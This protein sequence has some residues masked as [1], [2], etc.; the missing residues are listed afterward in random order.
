MQEVTTLPEDTVINPKSGERI[1]FTTTTQES[2]GE[3]LAFD[4]FVSP[5]GGVDFPHR[6][7]KQREVMR[8]VTGELALKVNGI[9]QVLRPGDELILEAG[10]VH[11]IIN[12]TDSEVHCEVEYRP[13]GRNEDWFRIAHGYTYWTGREPGM[14][15]L[16]PFV[17]DVDIYMPGPLWLQRFFFNRVLRPLGIALGRREKMLDIAEQVYGR[18][19]TW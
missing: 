9:R 4:F 10:D 12:E 11:T 3:V 6:H 14:L 8:G 15:D 16:A 19:F 5:G 17:A 18:K 2:G 7:I 1:V 13:A